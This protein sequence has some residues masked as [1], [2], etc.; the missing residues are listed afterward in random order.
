MSHGKDPVLP[1]LEDTLA[2]N[3]WIL[4]YIIPIRVKRGLFVRAEG[5]VSSKDPKHSR[6][7][8]K[9]GLILKAEA[10]YYGQLHNIL[11]AHMNEI[12]TIL[13]KVVGKDFLLI[14]FRGWDFFPL[15][16]LI[17]IWNFTCYARFTQWSL[18]IILYPVVLVVRL[19]K[20]IQG[21]FPNVR[22]WLQQLVNSWGGAELGI[23]NCKI[24]LSLPPPLVLK[25]EQF[26]VGASIP[27]KQK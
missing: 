13:I 19:V 9:R 6:S 5:G 18:Q 8:L 10:I 15:K 20:K 26:R 25:Q 27:G 22:H 14:F 24:I 16:M 17:T 1:P 2:F 12:F 23:T 11:G 7:S 3:I 21:V 4:P